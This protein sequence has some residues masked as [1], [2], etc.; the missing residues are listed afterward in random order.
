[1]KRFLLFLLLI[2]LYFI[3]L[4]AQNDCGIR[5]FQVSENG[6]ISGSVIMNS[7]KDNQI[8]VRF[9]LSGKGLFATLTSQSSLNISKG[10][11]FVFINKKGDKI[12]CPFINQTTSLSYEGLDHFVNTFMMNWENMKW[13]SM[14]KTTD[15]AVLSHSLNDIVC[16]RI[17]I[18]PDA[19]KEILLTFGCLNKFAKDNLFP[20]PVRSSVDTVELSKAKIMEELT[21]EKV[22]DLIRIYLNPEQNV[23]PFSGVDQPGYAK[24]LSQIADLLQTSGKNKKAEELF[25]EAQQNIVQFSGVDYD[26]YPDLLNDLATFY[27]KAGDFNKAKKHYREAK[28]LIEKVFGKRH[29][30]YPVTLNNLGSL[31]LTL[32]EF[33]DSETYHNQA[34]EVLEKEFSTTHPEYSNT[35]MHLS[36]FYRVKKEYSKALEMLSD[37]SKNI[38]HQLY[39]YYPSLNDAERL[40]FLKKMNNSVHQFYSSAI[41]ILPDMPEISKE[42][43]NISLAVKGLALEG[44]ISARAA[45]LTSGDSTLR[46]KFYNWLGVRRQLVQASL[47]PSI[48]REMFGL[49]IEKLDIR[50][51]NLEKELSAASA[52][53]ANQFKLRRMHLNVDSVRAK[54]KKDEIAVDFIHFLYHDGKDWIDSTLYYALVIKKNQPSPAL[55][56]LCNHSQLQEILNINIT[57]KSMSYINNSATNR[58]LYDLIFKPLVPSLDSVNKIYISPSGLLHQ[59]AFPALLNAE[60][61]HLL[62]CFDIVNFGSFR[63][64]V[65]PKNTVND[66]RDIVLAGGAKFSVDSASLVRLMNKMKDTSQSVNS[67]DLY[68]YANT[69]LPFSRALASNF[70]RGGLFFSY[71]EGTK[72]EVDGIEAFLH[73]KNWITHKYTGEDALED[74]VKMH[75]AANAPFALHIATHG[76]FFKPL[77]PGAKGSKEF[78]K[79]IIYAQ[80]PLMRTGLVLTGA[81]RVWQ[82]KAPVKGLDDGIL[83]AYEISNLDL[84]KTDLVVLSACETGLGDIN[85]SEGI[86]G[87]QRALKSAGVRQ[88]LVTLWRIP[89]EQ[90]AVLMKAFYKYYLLHKSAALALRLAQ[91]DMQ[92]KYSAYFWAGF[93]LIE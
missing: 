79:Q 39:S 2:N 56:P 12:A 76:Y 15:F 66:V 62:N 85:D 61:Q 21:D 16:S 50:A 58:K 23:N 35:L 51:L 74:K 24:T 45:L 83:T 81:N 52:A 49:N 89:D 70:S 48:E 60:N 22:L 47:M 69:A 41:H 44:S 73:T 30:D 5:L 75:T 27:R 54:L 82:G 84:F 11:H 6:R 40:V 20:L 68:A 18:N 33:E 37:L 19:A 38:I 34:R 14:F 92:K 88:L 80:N 17:P 7:K 46:D 31:H 91:Q 29:P 42:V 65:Y 59:I 1:M 78:Y 53:L 9:V 63:D 57:E 55:I 26:N 13:L 87:L 8:A 25:L 86:F 71:L 3:S 72:K 93:V 32:D 10:D 36:N 28:D 77:M 64:F 43:A 4:S 90:T 67:Y